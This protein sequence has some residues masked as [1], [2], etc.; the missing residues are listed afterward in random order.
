[1]SGPP[2][3]EFRTCSPSELDRSDQKEMESQ[4]ARATLSGPAGLQPFHPFL[5]LCPS[6]LTGRQLA[7]AGLRIPG[8]ARAPQLQLMDISDQ[9]GRSSPPGEALSPEPWTSEV[10]FSPFP[11][12][13]TS[14]CG[15][16]WVEEQEFES[17]TDL[18]PLFS[19][20]V[21]LGKME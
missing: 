13:P 17:H 4:R 14:I 11:G 1:M 16:S 9:H 18:V 20:C 6:S 3:Q 15:G 10:V 7:A 8:R 5:E 21:T 19:D 12:A 2:G